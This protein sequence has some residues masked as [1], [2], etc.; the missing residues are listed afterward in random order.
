MPATPVTRSL[1][2]VF[3][4]GLAVTVYSLYLYWPAGMG[5]ALVVAITTLALVQRNLGKAERVTER[6]E[7]LLDELLLLSARR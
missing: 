2:V 4:V 3:A 5:V 1:A 6:D 7:D